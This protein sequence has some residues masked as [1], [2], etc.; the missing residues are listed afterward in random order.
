MQQCVAYSSFNILIEKL[1]ESDFGF[2]KSF[3]LISE[4]KVLQS[5]HSFNQGYQLYIMYR[6][7]TDD[8]NIFMLKANTD[9]SGYHKR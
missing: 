6:I 7:V 4:H 1:A 3:R 2:F 5:H 8:K 9:N